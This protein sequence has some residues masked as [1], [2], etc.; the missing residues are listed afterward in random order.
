MKNLYILILFITAL[1]SM[2]ALEAAE[3]IE[4]TGASWLVSGSDYILEFSKQGNLNGF[5]VSG[6]KFEIKN[7]LVL[8]LRLNSRFDEL[9]NSVCKGSKVVN[10]TLVFD[11]THPDVDYSIYI[12]PH[13]KALDFTAKLTSKTG[14][15]TNAY[16][17]ARIFANPSDIEGITLHRSWPRNMGFEINSKFFMPRDSNSIA[18][19]YVPGARNEG[20]AHDLL[21]GKKIP[22]LPMDRKSPLRLGKDAKSW[23]GDD[24]A[25]LMGKIATTTSRP[26]AKELADIDIIDSDDGVYFGGTRLGGKGAI[27]RIGGSMEYSN[28]RSELPLLQFRAY[29][30]ALAET[31]KRGDNVRR[32]VGVISVIYNRFDDKRRLEKMRIHFGY[33]RDKFFIIN[34]PDDL[35]EAIKSPETLMIINPY[36]E[37]CLT[38]RGASMMEFMGMLK[39]FVRAGG[40]WFE[41]GGYP[42]FREITGTRW[43]N[44]DSGASADFAH[45]KMKGASFSIYGVQPVDSVEAL[46][47]NPIIYGK[48]NFEGT[49]QGA[50]FSRSFPAYLSK[51]ETLEL[52]IT[53]IRFGETLL[54]AAKSFC[55]D[56]KILKKL[57]EKSDPKFINKFKESLIVKIS[58]N[59]SETTRKVAENMPAPALLHVAC[60]LHGGF[61]KQYPDHLPPNPKYSSPEDFRG[62]IDFIH[63]Q[64]SMFMPYTNNTWWCDNPKGPTF[65]KYG[66]APL[67]KTAKGSPNP[68]LYGRNTGFTACQWHPTVRAANAEIIRQFTEDYPADIVFQDQ[69]G[70]RG[71]IPDYNPEAPSINSYRGGLLYTTIMDSRSKLLST[72]DG[73][74]HL[75]DYEIQFCGFTF[76]IMEPRSNGAAAVWNLFWETLP[77]DT[78]RMANY[79]GALFQ[80]KLSITH[81]NLGGNIK[82]PRQLALSVAYGMHLIAS[83]NYGDRIQYTPQNFEWIKWLDAVQKAGA[84]KYIGKPMKRFEHEW[85]DVNSPDGA[86]I[87][88]SKYGSVNIVANANSKALQEGDVTIA[89]ESFLLRA[90]DTCVGG[91]LKIGEMAVKEPSLF[92]SEKAGRKTRLKVY[93]KGGQE[94]IVPAENITSLNLSGKPLEFEHGK[95]AVKF[96]LP[97]NDIAY[98]I[99]WELEA[100]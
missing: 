79:V 87:I 52:P 43:L 97:K 37:D 45:F 76:G 73:W 63:S 78:V 56:N 99:L 83:V 53:R 47:K 54:K 100:L 39:D 19:E 86:S 20:A 74:A 77:K 16:F 65:E 98:P 58:G 18:L 33:L 94:V 36:K 24:A 84:S 68:E 67:S 27:F 40:Y 81:H 29:K 75:S 22:L 46:K 34:S 71:A 92:A 59:S 10:G 55:A 66:E 26:L 72:E 5:E 21:Y 7:P 13:S 32:K 17:P 95:K 90:P 9:K 44:T 3:K 1:I 88:R 61:D 96:V 25:E 93:A 30:A 35:L 38:P 41:C 91:V 70:S 2:S 12:T 69:T 28:E 6:K 60:Y 11:F 57:D 15:I 50:K 51:G 85:A 89:P 80:D 31:K 82:E 42:F 4:D 62:L 8:G 14:V 23:I 49:E 64:G 48:M